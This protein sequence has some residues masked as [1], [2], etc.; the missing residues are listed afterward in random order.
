MEHTLDSQSL[1]FHLLC[2]PGKLNLWK[3]QLTHLE[4]EE[5]GPEIEFPLHP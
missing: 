1:A 5:C 4:N 2:D 3:P